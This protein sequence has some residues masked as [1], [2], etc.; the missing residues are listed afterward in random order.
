MPVGV[1]NGKRGRPKGAKTNPL[2]KSSLRYPARTASALA[3][4]LV[5]RAFNTYKRALE[6][7][8]GEI[9]N[10]KNEKVIKHGVTMLQIAAADRIMDRAFGRPPQSVEILGGQQ[11]TIKTYNSIDEMVDELKRRGIT[12]DMLIRRYDRVL[13]LSSRDYAAEESEDQSPIKENGATDA[14][15]TEASI[16][17][18][19]QR[20]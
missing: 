13:T 14:E 7:N 9:R 17:D 2:I 1:H 12:P 4:P 16:I 11:D 8:C 20:F 19:D 18:I 5:A 3:M 10:P 15:I 6:P